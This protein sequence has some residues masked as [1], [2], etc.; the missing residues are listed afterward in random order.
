MLMMTL[1]MVAADMCMDVLH[2]VA[3][4]EKNDSIVNLKKIGDHINQ[5]FLSKKY[6]DLFQQ[7]KRP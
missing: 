5:T 1:M 7:T 4:N 3:R 2:E 6:Y